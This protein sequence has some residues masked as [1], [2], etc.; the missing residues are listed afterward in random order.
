MTLWSNVTVELL[1]LK[2][3]SAAKISVGGVTI[4][5]C[6]D[7]VKRDGLPSGWRTPDFLVVG[8]S[9]AQAG[10]FSPGCTV[11]SVDRETLQKSAGTV[12]KSRA[13]W[14]GG[15]GNLVLNLQGDRRL[16]VGREK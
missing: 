15:Y 13:V 12:K 7:G 6:P 5:V 8:K 2:K 11:F 4:V 16:S 14:T 10:T 9:T 1:Q 3:A